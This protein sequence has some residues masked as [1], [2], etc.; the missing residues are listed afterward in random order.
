MRFLWFALL[1]PHLSWS[2]E[3]IGP[4]NGVPVIYLHGIDTASPGELERSNR[5]NLER[6]ARDLPARVALPRSPQTCK[7][8]LCW[9]PNTD[10]PSNTDQLIKEALRQSSSCFEPS[11]PPPILLGFSSGGYL[12][13]KILRYCL[14]APVRR[15]ISVGAAGT[16]ADSDPKALGD[17]L[18]LTLLVS[19]TEE[20]R[21]AAEAF[22]SVMRARNGSVSLRYFSGD[23]EL[24][25]RET[26]QLLQE[27]ESP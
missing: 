22:A 14:N 10:T 20:T 5:K 12:V 17:C 4:T 8:G 1:I 2:A 3:C 24:P 16:T 18:S 6:I 15:L 11:S 25:F 27:S 19:Q 13:N 7:R 9:N 26:L 21:P 23:H